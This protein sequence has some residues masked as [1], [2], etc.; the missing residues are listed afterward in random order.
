MSRFQ[1]LIPVGPGYDPEWLSAAIG[2]CLSQGPDVGV[3]LINDGN[4]ADGR[5]G[6]PALVVTLPD[7]GDNDMEADWGSRVTVIHRKKTGGV[8]VALNDG[9]QTLGPGVEFV[10]RLDADDVC[11]P[12]RIASQASWLRGRPKVLICGGGIVRMDIPEWEKQ[13]RLFATFP[14]SPSNVLRAGH[15]PLPHPTWMMRKAN[16]EALLGPRPY[17]EAYPWAE[18]FAMLCQVVKFVGDDALLDISVPLCGHR[19][20]DGRVSHIHKKKQEHSRGEALKWFLSLEVKTEEVKDDD[21]D[22]DDGAA[23]GDGRVGGDDT[24]GPDGT[25][26]LGGR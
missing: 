23:T 2:S 26:A 25:D 10:C 19:M 6:K 13:K 9:W 22:G 5:H 14:G 24:P 21:V 11:L 7:F 4:C 16:L 20:H 15:M 18:D 12:N 8:A 17:S 1:F 3:T